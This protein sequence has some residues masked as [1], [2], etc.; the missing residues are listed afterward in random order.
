MIS[1]RTVIGL[2]IIWLLLLAESRLIFGQVGILGELLV[3]P[4]LGWST[5][6]GHVVLL[7]LLIVVAILTFRIRF[8]HVLMLAHFCNA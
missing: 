7:G 8:G 4:L 5:A 2:L 6:V 1:G 3:Y